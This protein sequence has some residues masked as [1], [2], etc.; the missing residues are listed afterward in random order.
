[1]PS[2]DTPVSDGEFQLER[3]AFGRLVFTNARGALSEGCIPVRSFPIS[4]P[5][6]AVSLLGADGRELA[7]I[8]RLDA[9][10][11]ALRVLIEA[12]LAQREFAPRI[13]R[14]HGVS[15]FSTP[16]VWQIDTDR[17]ET[18]LQLNGEEDIRRLP[19]AGLLIADAQGVQFV[20]SDIDALDRVSRRL[21][22]RFL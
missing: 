21:L 12:E 18:R 3:N 14:I 8:E 17:G 16:S 13:L 19:G 4:A 20:V 1:M 22:E 10:P 11:Q 15:T 7:W 9:L 6:E 5:L 2:H